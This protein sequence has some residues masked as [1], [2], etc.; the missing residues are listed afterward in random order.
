TRS[1]RPPPPEPEP[2][3]RPARAPRPTTRCPAPGSR[4]GPRPPRPPARVRPPAR[5]WRQFRAAEFGAV[6]EQVLLDRDVMGGRVGVPRSLVVEVPAGAGG[7]RVV[8][9]RQPGLR[10]R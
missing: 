3:S 6:A 4:T 2:G 1:A 10:H 7:R 5:S 8:A 9:D